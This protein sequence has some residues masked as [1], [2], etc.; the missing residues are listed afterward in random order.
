MAAV[1]HLVNM[2]C[3]APVQP[4][5]VHSQ[6]FTLRKALNLGSAIINACKKTGGGGGL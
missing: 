2:E 5:L 3:H 1:L 6:D 4:I